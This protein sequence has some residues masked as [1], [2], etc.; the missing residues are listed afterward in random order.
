[1]MVNIYFLNVLTKFKYLHYVSESVDIVIQ[2]STNVSFTDKLLMQCGEK[3]YYLGTFFKTN[4]FKASE[5][6]RSHNLFL[7]K[8]ETLEEDL[9]LE[10]YLKNLGRIIST[11]S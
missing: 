8:I 7:A 2:V 1:M 6:C 4:Y 3:R 9:C 10:R 11:L 5:F